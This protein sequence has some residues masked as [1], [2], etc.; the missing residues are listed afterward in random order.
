MF[1]FSLFAA[2]CLAMACDASRPEPGAKALRGV[3]IGGWMVLEPWITP[4]MFYRFLGKTH[5]EGVG[6]DT[7]TFCEA[8]GAD[9]G[10]KV[11]RAHWD[12]WV[13]EEHIKELADREVEALRLPIG[14]WNMRQYG[15]YVGCTDGA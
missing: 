4:S 15:P 12:A 9:E 8:L 1:K 10:N 11:L 2:A 14:D 7:Y 5:S 13:T 3:N 6:M